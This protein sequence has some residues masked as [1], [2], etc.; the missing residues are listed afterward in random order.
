MH[1]AYY[2]AASALQFN[3]MHPNYFSA[4]KPI[5]FA[6]YYPNFRFKWATNV[7]KTTICRF[8]VVGCW[9]CSNS[10][11][12]HKNLLSLQWMSELSWVEMSYKYLNEK[13]IASDLCAN[14]NNRFFANSER[15][16][17]FWV[18]R[19]MFGRLDASHG[20]YCAIASKM[21]ELR[22]ELF[23]ICILSLSANYFF[24]AISYICMWAVRN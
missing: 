20:S 15:R 1:Y 5:V 11:A 24:P 22:T 3:W 23:W 21:S 12:V 13:F 19:R 14:F 4:R 9:L 7:G 6:E 2:C 17:T 16:I 8:F 18:V 10:C